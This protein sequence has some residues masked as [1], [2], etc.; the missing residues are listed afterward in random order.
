MLALVSYVDNNEV[1]MVTEGILP[2]AVQ[3]EHQLEFSNKNKHELDNENLE[4][5]IDNVAIDRD[6]SPK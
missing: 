3:A 2:L 5:N 6:L 4:R 1:D